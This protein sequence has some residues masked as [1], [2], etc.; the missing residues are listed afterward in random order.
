MNNATPAGYRLCYA[1]L[2]DRNRML[3]FP[4]DAAGRVD[5]ERLSRPALNDYLYARVFVGRQFAPPDVRPL[6][7]T[8]R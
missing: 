3:A 8:A 1:S 2:I 7:P 5:L 4:C 6:F